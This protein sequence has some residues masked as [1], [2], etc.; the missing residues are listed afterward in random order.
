MAAAR[1]YMCNVDFLDKLMDKQTAPDSEPRRDAPQKGQILPSRHGKAEP[2][3]PH[4]H[5]ESSD[6][7]PGTRD[8]RVAQAARDLAQGQHDTGRDPV[9]TEVA[10][11]AFPSPLDKKPNP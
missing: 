1:A 9:V 11:K 5:D 7:H 2:R 10:R 6:G 8:E 4:E 3:L